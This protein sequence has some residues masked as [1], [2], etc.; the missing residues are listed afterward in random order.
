MTSQEAIIV[1]ALCVIVM[2]SSW[3]LGYRHGRQMS[4]ADLAELR[5][6]YANSTRIARSNKDN[7]RNS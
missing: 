5:Q 6:L 4:E 1:L 7:H 2:L 3:Y